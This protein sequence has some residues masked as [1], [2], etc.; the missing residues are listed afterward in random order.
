MT[1]TVQGKIEPR[2]DAN[3]RECLTDVL[4]ALFPCASITG[5]PKA[6]TMELIQGL[7]TSP[8][9]IYTGSIG[10]ITPQGEACFSVAIRT[11]LIQNGTLEFGI[12]GG[13]VWD[14]DAEAEYEE[15]LTKARVL[16]QPRP[17]FQLL[18]TML[19]EPGTGIFLLNE[20]LQRVG[21]SAAYFDVPLDMHAVLQ[22]LEEL[23][24]TCASVR[25]RLLVSRDGNS[26]IQTLPFGGGQASAPEGGQRPPLQIAI[27]KEPVDSQDL[28]LY[29]KTTHRTVYEA[30]KADF[31]DCDDV[32]LWN[33]R[34]EVTESCFGNVVIRTGD[35]RITPPIA[36]GLLGGTFRE[37]VLKSGE[38]EEG[39]ISIDDLKAADEVFLVNSVRTWQKSIIT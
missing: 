36:C 25:I 17:D 34:G 21:K 22:A 32:I 35:K 15:T 26:E 16:T 27:A 37:H 24:H 5:A 12:G 20:H 18:E 19:W 9:K 30:A 6:K 8:R 33:E 31:P 4:K 28:F 23:P 7:E 39:I 2:M 11:A 13:I 14:S 3:G 1:S 29:H 38:V 10:F